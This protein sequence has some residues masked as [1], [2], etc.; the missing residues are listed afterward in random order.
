MEYLE[1]VKYLEDKARELRR[2]IITM[3]HEAQSGHP[4]G[5][6]SAADFVA[7]LYFDALRIRPSEPKWNERD[8]VILS[9]GHT[10]PVIYAALAMKGFYDLSE[11]HTLRKMGSILQGHPDMKKVPGLDMTSGSLGQGL[12]AGAGMAF[13]AK[14]DGLDSKVYVI[15]GDGELQ[16][17][18]VWE[19]AMTAAK[20]KLDNLIAFVDDNNL[21]VDGNTCE[22]MPVHPIADKFLAFGWEV[23]SID[24]HNIGEILKVLEDVKHASGKPKCIIA[25]TVKGKGVSYMEN[26]CDWHGA[27]PD[28]CQ[29]TTAMEE[30]GGA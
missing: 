21:Q 18:Q 22:I 19:A 13:G 5:S 20:Y 12:S 3:I 28:A 14:Y 2:H 15:L 26:A 1:K 10:C 17:G 30:L 7:V 25:N 4:G 23:Y 29:Y 8:R 6:L 11:I 9:K 27:C 16:E 24:G